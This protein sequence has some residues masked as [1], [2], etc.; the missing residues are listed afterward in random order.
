MKIVNYTMIVIVIVALSLLSCKKEANILTANAITFGEIEKMMKHEFGENAYYTDVSIRYSKAMGSVVTATVTN[1]PH[2]LKMEKW[3]AT[4]DVWKK[5]SDIFIEVPYGTLAADFMFRLNDTINLFT[6]GDLAEKSSIKLK[7]E[8]NIQNPALHLASII[9][10]KNG[11]ITKTEYCIILK[12]EN[13]NKTFSFFYTI[14]G[15]LIKTVS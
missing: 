8:N 7:N 2:S 6:L 9:F 15:K 3:N 5:I 10:P 4:E 14:E 12:P 11:D 13:S 1:V